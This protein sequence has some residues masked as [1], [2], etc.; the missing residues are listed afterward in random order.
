MNVLLASFKTTVLCNAAKVISKPCKNIL[1]LGL[2]PL[3]LVGPKEEQRRC[4]IY[5]R[6]LRNPKLFF[7]FLHGCFCPG[8]F[9]RPTLTTPPVSDA[10][11]NCG[12]RVRILI[13]KLSTKAKWKQSTS[14][15]GTWNETSKSWRCETSVI[16][17]RLF[18]YDAGGVFW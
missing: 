17:H 3:T 14:K 13:N 5:P 18:N 15:K 2:F 4:K 16:R 12:A 1:G 10:D 8:G 6:G 9:L 7:Q 11:N